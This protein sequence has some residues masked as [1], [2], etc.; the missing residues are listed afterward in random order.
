M[1]KPSEKN[2]EEDQPYE[3]FDTD[4]K[5]KKKKEPSFFTGKKVLIGLMIIAIAIILGFVLN[6][7]FPF[8]PGA[9][10]KKRVVKI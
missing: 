2:K 8:L 9:S 7:K 1:K 10:K 4:D 5:D 6:K 3:Q